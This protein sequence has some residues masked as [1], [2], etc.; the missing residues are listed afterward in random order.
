MADRCTRCGG[1]LSA[2]ALGAGET[3]HTTGRC[4]KRRTLAGD[5]GRVVTARVDTTTIEAL[6]AA[7]AAAGRNRSEE[8]R[9]RLRRSV[10]RGAR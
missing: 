6:D 10:R 2:E 5:G 1:H 8:I 3:E 7:A 4:A 9:R